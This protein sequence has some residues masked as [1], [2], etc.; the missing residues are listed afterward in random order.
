MIM[1]VLYCTALHVRCDMDMGTIP[2]LTFIVGRDWS[3]LTSHTLVTS[4]DR[5]AHDNVVH[6][7]TM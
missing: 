1:V 7:H 4:C 2:L 6:T 3:D 5:P